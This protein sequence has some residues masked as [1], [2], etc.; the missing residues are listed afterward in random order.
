MTI[1]SFYF[2]SIEMICVW[3]DDI[4]KTSISM[5]IE[6]QESFFKNVRM[7]SLWPEN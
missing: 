7:N 4:G 5:F 1:P 6:R 2:G 3:Q